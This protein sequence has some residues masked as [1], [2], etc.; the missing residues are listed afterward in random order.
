VL[1]LKFRCSGRIAAPS[2]AAS[3]PVA[4]TGQAYKANAWPPRAF[5]D[6]AHDPCR[7]G[8]SVLKPPDARGEIWHA[9]LACLIKSLSLG[10]TAG[11][12]D[13]RADPWLRIYL[14]VELEVGGA[15]FEEVREVAGIGDPALLLQ[16]PSATDSSRPYTDLGVELRQCL[17]FHWCYRRPC[18]VARRPRHAAAA[19]A[20]T[21]VKLVRVL[22]GRLH[23][24]NRS[25]Y[26]RWYIFWDILRPVHRGRCRSQAARNNGL[27]HAWPW[28]RRRP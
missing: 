23:W 17:S 3:L 14:A 18:L 26:W 20:G 1:G 15:L 8:C 7:I 2:A 12:R 27:R 25:Y 24:R 11:I 5:K 9:S 21:A 22:S 19:V 16:A 28:R 6:D 10:L 13:L 4:A